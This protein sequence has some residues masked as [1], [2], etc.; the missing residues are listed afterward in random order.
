M[1][2]LSI[3]I[4]SIIMIYATNVYADNDPL[5][6]LTEQQK[7]DLLVTIA[8]NRAVN[9]NNP[10]ADVPET[11]EKLESISKYGKIGAGIAKGLGAAARELDIATNEFMDTPAGSLVAFMLVYHF[12]GA[13]IIG[14]FVGFFIMIPLSLYAL[15]RALRW[16]RVTE[17]EYDEK[18]NKRFL[19]GSPSTQTSEGVGW[20]YAIF[21]ISLIVQVFI[22]LP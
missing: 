20:V 13:D 15:N 6:G 8:K 14:F 19:V 22:F 2:H 12:I 9:A 17:I 3:L 18:G 5:S 11:I 1:K 16:C 7:A 10:M 21:T 4:L